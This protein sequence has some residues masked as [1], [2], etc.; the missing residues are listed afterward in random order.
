VISESILE[1][2]KVR[3]RP[4]TPDDLPRFTEWLQ[5]GEVRRW[6]AALTDAPTLAEEVDWY[7]ST[8]EN[9]DNVLWAIDTL[10]GDLIG[11]IELRLV[12]P[13]RRAELGIAIQDKTRW[14][15][16]YGTDAVKTVLSYGF[17]DLDLNR[18]D[19]TTDES[20]VRGRRCYQKCGFV[21]EGV[22]RQHRFIDGEPSNSIAMAILREEWTRR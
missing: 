8:R 20:N 14:N 13:A 4:V 1:G 22:L 18:I 6:L 21:E 5:D 10:D 19:L 17:E 16:G 12:P 15:R 7:E 9:P 11:A 3:L 2:E